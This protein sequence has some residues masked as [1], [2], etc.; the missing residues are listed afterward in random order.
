MDPI[1]GLMKMASL[2]YGVCFRERRPGLVILVYHRVGGGTSS[3]IDVPVDEFARQMAYLRARYAVASLDDVLQ[4]PVRE[5]LGRRADAVVVTFDDGHRETYEHAFPVLLQQ[6]IPATVYLATRF[7]ETQHPFDF[8][9]YAQTRRVDPLT[10]AQARE[11]A[12]SGLVTFGAHTHNHVDLTRVPVDMARAE[13]E[14]SHQLIADRLGAAPV[15]FAYPW[16]RV[17]PH[18]RQLVGERFRT[19]VRGGCRKNPFGTFD[20]L[21][22]WRRPIQQWDAGWLFRL[23][24]DSYLDAE[25]YFRSVAA[26][27][28]R[29]AAAGAQA[30]RSPK[31]GGGRP[32]GT[33][34]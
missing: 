17:N 27:L 22:L 6:R 1:A 28:K 23:K 2:P 24:L 10:W 20:L 34:R 31:P 29:P 19:A 4:R 30:W 33:R 3:D 21:T 5:D 26:R 9:E 15:H 25:E 11:M 14:R 18:V 32:L 8:G 16:G 7:V 13:V 12:D